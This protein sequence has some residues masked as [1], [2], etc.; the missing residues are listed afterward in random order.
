MITV[1]TLEQSE[2]W[3]QI[4]RSFNRYDVYY[5]SGYVKAFQLNGDGEPILIYYKNAN[6][7]A[8]NVVIRRD[9]AEYKFFYGKLEKGVL[10]DITT[11]YGYGGFLVEGIDYESLQI[12]YEEFCKN[13]HIICEF[14]RF[15]P[16]L[17]NWKGL[18]NLYTEIHLGET[19]Y[20]DTSSEEIVWQNIISK[21][22]NM[23]R[24]AQKNGLKVYWGR[25][26]KII[27][28][29]IEIYNKTMD[30]DKADEYYYFDRMFYESI[31]EDLKQNAMWFYAKKD[32]EITAIAIFMFCNGNMHYH[33]SASR[34]EYQK[35][36]PTNLIL[37][38]AARWASAQGY[39]KLHMGGG[40]GSEH[41]SLYK[42][43]KAFNRGEDLEF[44]IGK[45][46]FDE[47]KYNELVQF[48][49]D[50]DL[51]YNRENGYFPSYRG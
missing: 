29:F 50:T 36:A 21:N 47:E 33:L 38:E 32:D 10:Y 18:E 34:I 41:D 27:D 4:V 30:K 22:R 9:L 43:K 26:P 19:V 28:S 3:D 20:M 45:R 25:D 17:E 24:K 6:T 42:F 49:I 44:Y 11:P 12:E 46:I 35:M 13:E 5:L 51:K 37:Y 40:V 23:I 48:R 39:K 14:V 31:L 2:E 1:Y 15:H 16:L 8:I 7:R